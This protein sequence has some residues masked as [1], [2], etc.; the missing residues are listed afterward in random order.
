MTKLN[1][2]TPKRFTIDEY[3][4]LI[5]LGFLKEGESLRDGKAER[6]ELIQ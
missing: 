5:E 2:V 6:I 4:Q 1:V 3:H